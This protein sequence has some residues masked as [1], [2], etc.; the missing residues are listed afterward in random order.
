MESRQAEFL[1]AGPSALHAP[2]RCAAHAHFPA[3]GNESR[4]RGW[5][6]QTVSHACL[7]PWPV[8]VNTLRPIIEHL[9]LV[10]AEEG[11]RFARRSGGK[12]GLPGS[13]HV[14]LQLSSLDWWRRECARRHGKSFHFPLDELP[15]CRAPS[16]AST[17]DP[18]GAQ[19]SHQEKGFRYLPAQTFPDVL[20]WHP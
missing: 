6:V 5:L 8:P 4:V 13:G 3:T 11:H 14:L 9:R 17:G 19:Q 1:R 18:S 7:L 20:Y 15:G 2:R 10:P 12:R 16:E